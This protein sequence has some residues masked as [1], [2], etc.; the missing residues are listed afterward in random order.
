MSAHATIDGSNEDESNERY[1]FVL[2]WIERLELAIGACKGVADLH[3]ANDG[4]SH[5]DI[6]SSNFLVDRREVEAHAGM[7]S[8][9][10]DNEISW[11]TR[12]SIA[13]TSSTSSTASWAFR[14]KL[15]DMEFASNGVT[16]EHLRKPGFTPNWTA[17]EVK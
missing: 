1:L 9:K 10:G 13:S 15:A 14:V 16:P 6:K 17:P 3:T 8:L 11:N 7:N 5:N 4:L 2:P 12:R